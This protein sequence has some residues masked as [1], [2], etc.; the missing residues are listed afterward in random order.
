M[1]PCDE[2]AYL[3]NA[4]TAFDDQDLESHGSFLP[5]LLTGILQI[6]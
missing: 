4:F 3:L 5:W 2:L 6:F 1:S